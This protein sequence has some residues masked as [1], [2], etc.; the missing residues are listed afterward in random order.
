[1]STIRLLTRRVGAVGALVVL[2]S[3]AAAA[4]AVTRTAATLGLQQRYLQGLLAPP[5]MTVTSISGNTIKSASTAT[6][7]SNAGWQLQVTLSAPV[8]TNLTVK[9]SVGKG[10]AITL[11]AA[12]PT[13]VVATGATPCV[14]CPVVMDWDFTYKVS[15]RNAPRPTLA[16][17][18]YAVLP[19][20]G[21][22]LAAP[23]AG[24]GA[25]GTTTTGI[26]TTTGTTT[27]DRPATIPPTTLPGNGKK[28]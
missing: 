6:V 10:K 2:A 5:P 27:T 1:M 17:V 15:G 7:R 12:S 21:A 11:T 23:P 28:P 20:A 8:A 18:T 14:A 25:M 22:A 9:V 16:P 19:P 26:T 24:T 13:A 3:C 4:Q